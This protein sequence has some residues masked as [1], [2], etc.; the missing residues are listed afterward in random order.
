MRVD[1]M[2]GCCCEETAGLT[3]GTLYVHQHHPTHCFL[4]SR[5][6]GGVVVEV[7]RKGGEGPARAD[8]AMRRAG[9]LSSDGREWTD[10][11]VDGA[12]GSPRYELRG[13]DR[14]E[15]RSVERSVELLPFSQSSSC[16]LSRC[17][18]F[19]A[20]VAWRQSAPPSERT[21]NKR[22]AGKRDSQVRCERTMPL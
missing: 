13:G 9:S 12:G 11:D 3:L 7:V 10:G 19:A 20:S 15:P 2:H 17:A 18:M 21:A 8:S 4:E 1:I 6:T 16:G 5:D 14:R 22:L